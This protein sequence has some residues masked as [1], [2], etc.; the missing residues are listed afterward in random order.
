[1]MTHCHHTIYVYMYLLK[2]PQEV[3]TVSIDTS[4]LVSWQALDPPPD[5]YRIAIT[6]TSTSNQTYT[7][8]TQ[9]YWAL[10]QKWSTASSFLNNITPKTQ[11]SHSCELF[12]TSPS[13]GSNSSQHVSGVLGFVIAVLV[14]LLVVA[15]VGLDVSV[16]E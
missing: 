10:P 1:M 7:I 12:Q 5:S 11:T 15:G 8:S 9:V 3:T 2:Q 4:V 6:Y 13:H 14:L 16:Q